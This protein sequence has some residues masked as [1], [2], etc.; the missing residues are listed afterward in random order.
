VAAYN[1][2]AAPG[3][4]AALRRALDTDDAATALRSLGATLGV[5]AGLRDLGVTEDGLAR[6]ADE[7]IANPYSNPRRVTRPELDALLHAAW[8]GA[9]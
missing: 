1:L 7:V 2:P 4:A 9:S 6:V 8:E 3:A 5:P